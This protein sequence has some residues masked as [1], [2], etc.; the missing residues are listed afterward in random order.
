MYHTLDMAA[1]YQT[2]VHYRSYMILK[3]LNIMLYVPQP[4]RTLKSNSGHRRW[5][6][7]AAYLPNYSDEFYII[8][9]SCM[10]ENHKS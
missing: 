7:C 8:F 4:G 2:K 3:N 9:Q 1:I 5:V 6:P 10:H